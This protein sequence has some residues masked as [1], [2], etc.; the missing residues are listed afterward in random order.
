MEIIAG[1]DIRPTS[2]QNKIH[3]F[4]CV[5]AVYASHA[6]EQPPGDGF[7]AESIRLHRLPQ[8]WS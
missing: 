7:M 1:G 6:P 8:S 5:D 4:P 3:S 2:L